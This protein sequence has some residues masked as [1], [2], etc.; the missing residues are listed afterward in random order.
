MLVV[1]V[2]NK[3]GEPDAKNCEDEKNW[4]EPPQG[5]K[6]KIRSTPSGVIKLK[7]VER[8]WSV[9]DSSRTFPALSYALTTTS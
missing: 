8:I 9:T 6:N 7:N 2:H 4:D 3:H 1:P 5:T